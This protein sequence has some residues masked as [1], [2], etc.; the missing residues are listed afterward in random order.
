MEGQVFTT[1]IHPAIATS[2]LIHRLCPSFGPRIASWIIVSDKLRRTA[3]RLTSGQTGVSIPVPNPIPRPH[4]RNSCLC[5]VRLYCGFEDAIEVFD[6]HRPREGTRL[7]T[8]PSKKSRDG[9]KGKFSRISPRL[10]AH[11]YLIRCLSAGIVSALA[12]APDVS[13]DIYAAGSFSPSSP[14][15]SNIA[16]FSEASGEVPIMFVG[17][18]DQPAGGGA[19]YGVR[20]SVSQ[21]SP[22]R[23]H[24]IRV[25]D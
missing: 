20:A 3:W 22:Q 14:S 15:S 21:V 1:S 18:E 17:A 8:T 11:T 7:R 16:I 4:V 5:G 10:R 6:I 2:A 9:L 24:A 13:S 23:P 19:G 12:F 25:H